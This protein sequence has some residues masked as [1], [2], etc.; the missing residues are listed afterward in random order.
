MQTILTFIQI[1][2]ALLLVTTILLQRRGGGLSSVF[3]GDGN[4][5]R[6]RR[7]A[8][9]MIFRATVILAALF[10]ATALLNVIW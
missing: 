4:V 10:L 5:Y 2:V 9:K 3:G 7:G 6:T 8:E 1:I